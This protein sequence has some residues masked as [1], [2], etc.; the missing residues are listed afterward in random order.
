MPVAVLD[1]VEGLKASLA[2][3]KKPAAEG[4]RSQAWLPVAAAHSAESS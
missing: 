1:I 4:R 3:A 2:R